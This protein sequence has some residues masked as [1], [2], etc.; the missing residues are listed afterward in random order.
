MGKQRWSSRWGVILAVT[1]CAVGLGNFLR[2]PGLAAQY[3]GAFMIPYFLALLLVGLPLAWAEWAMGR[4]GGVRG[5]NS[6]PGIYRLVCGGSTAAACMGVLA[7]IVPV[8]VYMYYVFIEAWCLGYA[9][10]YLAGDLAL[11][12]GRAASEQFFASF[13]GTAA[14]GALLGH[15]QA[16]VFLALCVVA[17]FWLVA[18]GLSGGIEW[19]CV[20]AMPV[21]VVCALLVLVRVL[22]LG[23]P[24]PSHPERNVLAGLGHMWNPPADFHGLLVALGNPKMWLEA[25]GQIF[26]TLGVGFGIVLNYSSYLRRNDDLALSAA[27]AVAGNEFCEVSLGGLIT[28]P[29][30]FV[31]FGAAGAVGGTFGLGFQTLPLVFELMPLGRAVGFLFFFLLFLAAITSSVSMLQPA[32]AFLEE[33]LG[34]DR[35]R[36][37]ALLGGITL[38]GNA[39]V[40]GFS[41]GMAAL[42]AMDFWVGTFCI[43][44][45]ATFQ[46]LLFGWALGTRR[47]LE[48]LERGAAIRIPHWFPFVIRYVTPAALLAILGCWLAQNFRADLAR[49]WAPLGGKVAMI[50]VA[51][52]ALLFLVFILIA[53]RRWSAAERRAP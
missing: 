25:T 31:F 2:F 17:N 44:V 28:V 32:I 43:Y 33:G 46:T 22:T 39:L 29:A 23:A 14:D 45:L 18:R 15:P 53:V 42:D 41:G 35:K 50:F 24:D 5:F 8:V 47:G 12:G 40:C 11:H 48:E 26:F 9:W 10:H 20:R 38:A 19:F 49:T 52:C 13:A 27:T 34:L 3:G 1:G 16:L 4:H 21:L 6:S 36:A 30:A 7:L 51:A 37:L